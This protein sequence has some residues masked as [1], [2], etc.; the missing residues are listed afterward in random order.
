MKGRWN[1]RPGFAWGKG[2]D[3]RVDLRFG[4]AVAPPSGSCPGNNSICLEAARWDSAPSS[5]ADFDPC[6][7]S[8]P[9]EVGLSTT[10][11]VMSGDYRER[12]GAAAGTPTPRGDRRRA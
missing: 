9:T 3:Q 7:R 12:V 4:T 2:A 6:H 11:A 1:T 5:R 8:L 10:A